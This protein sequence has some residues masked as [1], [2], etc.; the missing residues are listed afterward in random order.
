[1]A[2]GTAHARLQCNTRG[3]SQVSEPADGSGEQRRR[4][5]QQV[6]DAILERAL[7]RA[8]YAILWERLW[9]ALAALATA[10]GLFL[11]VSWAGL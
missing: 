9:P 10:I 11:I 6:T 3:E 8:R 4:V 7:T 2:L 1:M 5:G